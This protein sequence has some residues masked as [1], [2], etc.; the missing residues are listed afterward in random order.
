[1]KY[2]IAF[3][4]AAAS[5]LIGGVA[6]ADT[7]SAT[8]LGATAASSDDGNRDRDEDERARSPTRTVVRN[9]EVVRSR[10][11]TMYRERGERPQRETTRSVS[12]GNN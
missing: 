9:G 5:L 2:R 6:V 3:A 1:M 4:A 8:A 11:S 10:T 7:G 12:R